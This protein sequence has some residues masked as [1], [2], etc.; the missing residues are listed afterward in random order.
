MLNKADENNADG[1]SQVLPENQ[2]SSPVVSKVY[3]HCNLIQI[4]SH[5]K[6]KLWGKTRRQNSQAQISGGKL[7]TANK[8]GWLSLQMYDFVETTN[9]I[10]ILHS[11]AILFLWKSF[12]TCQQA[13][14][15]HRNHRHFWFY[16]Y[17]PSTRGSCSLKISVYLKKYK[18]FSINIYLNL[19]ADWKR[20]HWNRLTKITF[21]KKWFWGIRITQW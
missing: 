3:F 5:S 2:L 13:S 18:T 8:F 6:A 15:H 16:D 4:Y 21:N 14:H 11:I 9:F 20:F 19:F 1:L 17:F 12:Y 10:L 7:L